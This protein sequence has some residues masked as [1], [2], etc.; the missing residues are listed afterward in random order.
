MPLHLLNNKKAICEVED[1]VQQIANDIHVNDGQRTEDLNPQTIFADGKKKIIT[2]LCKYAQHSIPV[3]RALM[4]ELQ[5]RLDVTPQDNSL[6]EEDRLL[7]AALLQQKIQVLQREINE[8]CR[9][10]NMV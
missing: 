1:V 6:L 2:I 5:A 7:T 8:K 10:S 4:E 9:T 3:K